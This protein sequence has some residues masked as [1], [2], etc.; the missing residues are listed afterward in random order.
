MSPT[1]LSITLGSFIG[2][3]AKSRHLRQQ[4][5]VYHI[6]LL[7]TQREVCGREGALWHPAP[8][9]ATLSREGKGHHPPPLCT[10]PSCTDAGGIAH[11][12]VRRL[13]SKGLHFNSG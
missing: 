2:Q 8:Q 5:L 3:Q 13:K 11:L 10:L 9:T 1:Q 4:S 6:V 12:T 7:K